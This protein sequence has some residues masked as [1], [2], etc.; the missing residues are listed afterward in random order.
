MKTREF[1]VLVKKLQLLNPDRRASS[2]SCRHLRSAEAPLQTPAAISLRQKHLKEWERKSTT[3]HPAPW[4]P[5]S[6]TAVGFRSTGWNGSKPISASRCPHRPN[7]FFSS[8]C[9][10]CFSSFAD[11]SAHRGLDPRSPF[12]FAASRR[13]FANLPADSRSPETRAIYKRTS[14][15]VSR[16]GKNP[17]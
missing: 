9:H 17:R 7:G 4:W 2:H 6:S 8:V 14:T 3:R 13:T 16:D 15:K 10:G 11:P 5:Y 12:R 1:E